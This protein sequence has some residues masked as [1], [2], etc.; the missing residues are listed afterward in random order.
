MEHELKAWPAFFDGVRDGCKTFEVRKNDRGF[1]KGDTLL[2]RKWDPTRP[3]QDDIT[4]WRAEGMVFAPSPRGYTDDEPIRVRVLY[5]LSGM[6]IEQEYVVMGIEKVEKEWNMLGR[7]C[8]FLRSSTLTGEDGKSADQE[9]IADMLER[10][11]GEKSDA[12]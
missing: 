5:V 12:E 8:A 10:E 11:F 1:Q 6:G 7:I 2:L 3:I 4:M 9:C